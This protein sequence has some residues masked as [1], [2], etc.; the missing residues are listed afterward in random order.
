MK[1]AALYII[2]GFVLVVLSVFLLFKRNQMKQDIRKLQDSQN[3][4]E[5]LNQQLDEVSQQ[6]QELE[7]PLSRMNNLSSQIL[8]FRK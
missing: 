1:M 2:L 7:E 8:S 3:Q 5:E 4:I 6:L